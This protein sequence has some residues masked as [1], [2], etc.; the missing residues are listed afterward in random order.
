MSAMAYG[1]TMFNGRSIFLVSK[2]YPGVYWPT[3]P[4]ANAGGIVYVHRA[5]AYAVFG[6]S[7]F[8]KHVNHKNG[9]IWD[10]RRS[11]LIPLSP[12]DHRREHIS[13]PVER[14]CLK[15]GR[16]FLAPPN[17]KRSFCTAQCRIEHSQRTSWP[18]TTA[19]W[20]M[21]KDLGYEEVGRR[22]GVTGAAVKKRLK[23]RGFAAGRS[24][25]QPQ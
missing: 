16:I 18:E 6:E 14:N 17:R 12:E 22:L 4:T 13:E 23:V 15:C 10:W 24:P 7:M 1:K 8:D 20:C 2:G 19:L 21:A 3:H 11:N 25:K 5:V 9:D